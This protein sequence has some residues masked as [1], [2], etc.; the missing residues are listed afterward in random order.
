MPKMIYDPATGLNYRQKAIADLYVANFNINEAVKQIYPK[1]KRS[2]VAVYISRLRQN[3]DWNTYVANERSKIIDK[4]KWNL[5]QHLD[6]LREFA[7]E[8]RELKKYHIAAQLEKTILE[9]TATTKLDITTNGQSINTIK[10]I[11]I[12]KED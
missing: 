8:M 11:E 6:Y 3:E 9:Y 10:I 5:D 7:N 4:S 1:L 12:K 2:S